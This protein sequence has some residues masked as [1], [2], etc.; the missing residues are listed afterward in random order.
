MSNVNISESK[1]KQ[2]SVFAGVQTQGHEAVVDTAAEE[3]VIGSTAMLRLREQLAQHGLQPVQASGATVTCA[4]IGGSAKIVGVF[5]IPVGVAS[6]NGLLRV[7]EITDE[8]SFKTPFLLPISYIELV[9]AT[10]DTNREQFILRNGKS[11]PIKR[12]PSG[13]RTISI[14]DFF[15]N[16][17]M[18]PDQLRAELNFKDVNP[19]LIPKKQTRKNVTFQQRPG[20]AVW[21][22]TED[23]LHFMGI[24]KGRRN[25][26][27]DPKKFSVL[28]F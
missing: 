15:N 26:L 8:G 19:F 16:K 2:L 11:T 18:V 27:V 28:Q 7:T 22:K 14:M 24:L 23:R 3:A 10:I 6:T 4:G 21:M 17:W 25:T 1:E 12:V 9:G 5:D 20:V 13:H